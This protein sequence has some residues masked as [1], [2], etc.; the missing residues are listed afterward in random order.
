MVVGDRLFLQAPCDVVGDTVIHSYAGPYRPN[1][2]ISVKK[3]KGEI[4]F[5]TKGDANA[6]PNPNLVSKESVYG[7]LGLTLPKAGRFLYFSGTSNGKM[8]IFGIPALIITIRELQKLF[9]K[10]EG[11]AVSHRS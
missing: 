11:A 2:V 3:I 7:K 4:Y 8:I 10:P 6:T 5:Q 9:K 1:L